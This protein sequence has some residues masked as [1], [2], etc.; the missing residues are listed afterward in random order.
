MGDSTEIYRSTSLRALYQQKESRKT[1]KSIKYFSQKVEEPLNFISNFLNYK[2]QMYTF[3]KLST[4]LL[5][6]VKWA[7]VLLG[8]RMGNICY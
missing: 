1:P 6:L 3:V 8:Q 2:W 4:S 5:Y 7:A